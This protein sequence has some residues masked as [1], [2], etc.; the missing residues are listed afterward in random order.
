MTPS[1]LRRLREAP[2]TMYVIAYDITDDRRRRKIAKVA[3]GLGQRAQKSVFLAELSMVEHASLQKRLQQL[4]D[5]ETDTVI[6][7]PSSNHDVVTLG[8]P[9][10]VIA[11]R[12]IVA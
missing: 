11:P 3:E 1:N 5:P 6:L 9:I 10:P 2:R 4:I 12:L 8:R 7:A